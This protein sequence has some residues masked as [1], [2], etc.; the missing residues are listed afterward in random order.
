MLLK[1]IDLPASNK[2]LANETFFPIEMILGRI[3]ERA[4]EFLG[5]RETAHKTIF[6]N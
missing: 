2:L 4:L 3:T 5:R 6:R 1:T